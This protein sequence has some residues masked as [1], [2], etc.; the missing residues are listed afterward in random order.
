MADRRRD[1]RAIAKIQV[2]PGKP[3][4]KRP[5]FYVTG[6][7][8]VSGMFLITSDPLPEKTRI[9]LAF[10]VPG[11]HKKIH[12]LAEVVW[13]REQ[14]EK[15]GLPP[16]M[17]IRFISIKTKDQKNIDRYVRELLKEDSDT[18]QLESK[19]GKTEK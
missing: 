13:C 19:T 6:N 3:Y 15:P 9:K 18:L 16:G 10:Q 8:S 12:T 7:I 11:N 14:N 2:E 17:G 1:I 5:P 4:L